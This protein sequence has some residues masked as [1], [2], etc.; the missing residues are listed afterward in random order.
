M[1]SRQCEVECID[2]QIEELSANL[3]A[4]NLIAQVEDEGPRQM[5]LLG[6]IMDHRTLHEAIPTPQGTYVNSYE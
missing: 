3:I 1:D 4:V 5:M 2:R 6:E